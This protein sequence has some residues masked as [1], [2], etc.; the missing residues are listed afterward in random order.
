MINYS[1]R[2]LSRL[3]C[4]FLCPFRASLFSSLV[5]SSSHARMEEKLILV[6]FRY[7]VYLVPEKEIQSFL[8]DMK[9]SERWL[10]LSRSFLTFPPAEFYFSTGVLARSAQTF[11]S[12]DFSFLEFFFSLRLCSRRRL[13]ELRVFRGLNFLLNFLKDSTIFQDFLGIWFP[14]VPPRPLS[15]YWFFFFFF[16]RDN[17]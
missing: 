6:T 10:L 7:Q 17:I 4:P 14:V 13:D 12:S 9:D 5:L 1:S 16:K 3:I 8:E 15:L 11:P 2:I